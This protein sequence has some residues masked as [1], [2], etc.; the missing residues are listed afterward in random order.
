MIDLHH[1]RII[2]NGQNKT[3]SALEHLTLEQIQTHHDIAVQDM[4]DAVDKV[5]YFKAML[6][7]KKAELEGRITNDPLR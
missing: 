7:L 5:N 3:E 2:R 4:M 6:R 1:L